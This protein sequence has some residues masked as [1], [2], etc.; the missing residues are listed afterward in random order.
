M[1]LIIDFYKDLDYLGPGS[2][3]QTQKALSYIRFL[4]KIPKIADVGCGTGRQTEILAKET[5]AEIVAVDLLEDFLEAV[6]HRFSDFGKTVRTVQADMTALPFSDDEFDLIFSEGAIY[7]MGFEKGIREWRRF[8]KPGGFL[9]V[10]EISWLTDERPKELETYWNA[11]YSEMD[12]IAS[13]TAQLKKA[14]YKI[15]TH[16]TLPDSCWNTYYRYIQEKSESFLKKYNYSV[17]AQEFMAGC[18]EEMTYYKKHGKFYG[19]VFYI[20]QKDI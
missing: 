9:A 17:E 1:E 15:V 2:E 6:R 10:T 13:K 7:N 16:F 19:Y 3:E 5:N 11:G 12:T 4:S 20:A 18:K 8:I 14:G